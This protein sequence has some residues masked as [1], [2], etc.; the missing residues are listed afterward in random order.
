[1]GLKPIFE[2][3]REFFKEKSGVKLPT[4]CWRSGSKIYLDIYCDKPLYTFKIENKMIKITKN[5]SKLFENYEQVKLQETLDR[6][7]ERVNKLYNQSYEFLYNYLKEH[8]DIPIVFNH[9]GG[10]DSCL[11]YDVFKKVL[12]Q[13]E[14]EN[15][16]LDYVIS[17]ANTSNDTA[18]TYR[19]IKDNNNI[20]QDKLRIMNPKEGFY[21]WIR[22][23]NY[24]V[25]TA[26][27]RNCCSTFK[28][29]QIQKKY[30]TKKE[31]TMI[32]GVRK[33]ESVKR[34]NYDWVMNYEFYNKLFKDRNTNP[35]LWTNIAPIIEWYDEDVWIYLLN[36]NI[37]LNPQYEKGYNRCGCLIC[38]YQSDY[39][40]LLTEK[41]YPTLW[42]RWIE[43]I[44]PKS[45]EQQLIKERFKWSLE[46]FINKWWK[47]GTSKVYELTRK[48]PS[49]KNIKELKEILGIED[50]NIILKYFNKK[51]SKCNKNLNPTDIAM[52]LKIYGRQLDINNK[53]LCK[54]CMCNDLGIKGK[55]YGLKVR[56][57]R[58]GGCNLF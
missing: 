45:Y 7:R 26:L 50:E 5:N 33:H 24:L 56:E 30:N 29:G 42:K 36:N 57:F 28:E 54:K 1:M 13:L 14:E 43:D 12:K 22:R 21:P 48:S 23:N 49:Q 41:Y 34:A 2:Q 16:K 40:D 47:T 27:V 9:S 6:E 32:L 4:D 10:K 11:S 15:V 20:E 46:E 3:E 55:E 53:G 39:I 18:D 35:K 58:E 31:Y 17:F 19:F 52:N 8:K 38:P 37:P 51:C 25:P 44:L